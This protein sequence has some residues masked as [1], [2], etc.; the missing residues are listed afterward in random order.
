ATMTGKSPREVLRFPQLY[1]NH[2]A[3]ALV[4][5]PETGLLYIAVG[6]GG[7]QGDP[8]NLAQNKLYLNGKI[9]RI[10]PT[11]PGA[12]LPPDMGRAAEGTCSYP[13]D[14]PYAAPGDPGQDAIYAIGSRHPAPLLQ[15]NH[16]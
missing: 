15:H 3:D 12:T 2:G 6:D 8:Y 4:F 16:H 11:R 14:N 9:L 1:S 5:D 13:K 7:S 10:D